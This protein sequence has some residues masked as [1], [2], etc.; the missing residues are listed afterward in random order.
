MNM[1]AM[2]IVV[3]FVAH[4]AM[5]VAA[6]IAQQASTVMATAVSA[7]GVVHPRMAVGA[8]IVRLVVMRIKS[9]GEYIMNQLKRLMNFM[10][11]CGLIAWGI[12]WVSYPTSMQP[13]DF[14]LTYLYVCFWAYMIGLLLRMLKPK[15]PKYNAWRI[16]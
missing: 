10:L 4:V 9:K 7:V 14:S 5:V 16:Q 1:T 11:A 3:S 13:I 12:D 15:K 2:K 8:S 6:R